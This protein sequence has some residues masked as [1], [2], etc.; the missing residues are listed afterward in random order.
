[1]SADLPRLLLGLARGGY[2]EALSER[3]LACL[4][5]WCSAVSVPTALSWIA[6]DSGWVSI[7]SWDLPPHWSLPSWQL[8][9]RS[10]DQR[11]LADGGR[12]VLMVDASIA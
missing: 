10:Q 7:P 6:E 9:D 3:S 5:R 2:R 12:I 4:L 1:M 8:R 11:M